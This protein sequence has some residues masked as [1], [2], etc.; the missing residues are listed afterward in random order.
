MSDSVILEQSLS[1]ESS[2]VPDFVEKQILYVNDSNNSNYSSQIV[3][4]TTSLSNSGSWLAW[5]ESFLVI[6]VVLQ[7]QSAGIPAADTA[8]RSLDY[9]M[10]M[11]SGYWNLIH[12]MSVEF[13]NSSVVQQTPFLNVFSSFKALTSWSSEDVAN[14]GKIIGFCPD[15]CDAW[16]FNDAA[17]ASVNYS[18]SSGT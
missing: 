5:S 7:M 6:P 13:N 1:D 11:K 4:D 16:L 15:S 12:S 17:N 10:A 9:A 2:A 8:T 14:H 3:I 18:S